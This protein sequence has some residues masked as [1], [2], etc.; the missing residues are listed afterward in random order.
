MTIFLFLFNYSFSTSGIRR[1]W[2]LPSL[3]LV[4]GIGIGVFLQKYVWPKNPLLPAAAE[5]TPRSPDDT[6]DQRE[7][8]KE[9]D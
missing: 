1:L 6:E 4:L 3:V 9:Q 8:E 7:T 2:L 5:V